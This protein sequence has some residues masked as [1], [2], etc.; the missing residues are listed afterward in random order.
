[1]KIEDEID[2]AKSIFEGL[3]AFMFLVILLVFLNFWAN[4]HVRTQTQIDEIKMENEAARSV[5]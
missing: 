1:M 4:S 3:L 5:K 2:V